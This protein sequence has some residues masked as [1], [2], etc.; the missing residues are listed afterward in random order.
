[1]ASN[2]ALLPQS[3]TMF[4]T[5]NAAANTASAQALT[6]PGQG[7]SAMG[8]PAVPPPVALVQNL[9]ASVVW[10]SITISVRVA[11]IP[12][13]GNTTVEVPILPG[14]S[15]TFRAPWAQA[16]SGAEGSPGTPQLGGTPGS[17]T[18]QLNTIS[19]GVSVP[20]AVTFGEGL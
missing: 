3:N 6:F 17:T 19:P 7:A 14:Q 1:M 15:Q 13:N 9:G 12:A 18:L 10:V 11:A 16:S 2:D 8:G 20:L 5:T 4:V